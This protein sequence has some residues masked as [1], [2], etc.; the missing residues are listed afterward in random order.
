MAVGHDIQ[1]AVDFQA[2]ARV[3]EHLPRDVIRQGVLLVERRVTEYCVEAERLHARQRVIDHKFA[4]IQRFRQVGFHVQT[5]GRYRHWRFVAEHHAGLRVLRQ[6]R[7]ANH[8]VTAAEIHDF[9]FQVFRQMFHKEACADIQTGTGEN[10]RVVVDSP[11][12]A[13]Q[14]PAQRFWRV[15]QRRCAEGTVDQARFLPGKRRG[16]RAEHFL[17]QFQRR[18]VNIAR[19]GARDDARIRRHDLTQRAKLLLQQ[20]HGFGHF[21]QHHARRLRVVRGAVEE[22]HAGFFD[23]VVTQ[24]FTRRQLA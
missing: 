10:V 14:F 15:G 13:F 3:V 4:A 11:V 1:L 22:L 20:R 2:A 12:G 23:I 21:N 24:V 7:Q 16:G 19:F 18:G 5:A 6:Q 17:E 8:A 9:P